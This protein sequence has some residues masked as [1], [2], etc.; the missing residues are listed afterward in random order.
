MRYQ[1]K[2]DAV[3]VRPKPKPPARRLTLRKK[4]VFSLLVVSACLGMLE[5]AA[6]VVEVWVPPRAVDY[7][8][9]FDP[10]SRLFEPSPADPHTMRTRPQ[11]LASFR[12]QEFAS[13]KPPGTLRIVAIGG[14]SVN[15][16]DD[17]LRVLEGRL[18]TALSPRYRRVEI[19][20][21]G[22]L[23]YGSHRL[24]RVAAEVLHDEPD[25]ILFYEAHNEFEE[26]E[27]LRL[28]ANWTTRPQEV[29]SRLAVVRVISDRVT[30]LRIARLRREHVDRVADQQRA[31]AGDLPRSAR[32]WTHRFTRADVAERMESFRANM[33]RIVDLCEA[34][35]VPLV[36]TTVP[37]NLVKPYLAEEAAEPYREV[38]ELIDRGE[39]ERAGI[40]GR[41]VLK[42]CA[43][44][45]QSSDLENDILRSIAR[46]RH[47]PLADVEAA[48]IR[49][50]P[51]RLPGE[52]LFKDH[53]HLNAEGN[54]ILRATMEAEVLKIFAVPNG[55]P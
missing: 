47:V 9:G 48:V 21:C 37:S 54:T 11:K 23:S 49:A 24:A 29:A 6:R 14:S 52:T 40:R 13:P 5:L 43:G 55:K 20:N 25:L 17:E 27:Q 31:L 15:Y 16:L 51:H 18:K 33:T 8:Q 30:A 50:E 38:R 7:G 2:R 4:V 34:R 22:G 53:C 1:P 42:E 39:F 44:R 41:Q 26:V 19:L 36:L 28:A 12:H 10:D 45:H 3:E 46:E 35:G 32:A